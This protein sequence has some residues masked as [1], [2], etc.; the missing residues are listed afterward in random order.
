MALFGS[1]NNNKDK[2]L[3]VHESLDELGTDLADY[4]A[5]L[6]ESSVKERGFF[7]LAISGGSLIGLMG[8]HLTNALPFK[9]LFFFYLVFVFFDVA[10]SWFDF[11]I[12]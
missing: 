3:R 5:E 12:E 10:F 4:I 9:E 1:H 2:E 11:V 7:A 8:Y 6:A